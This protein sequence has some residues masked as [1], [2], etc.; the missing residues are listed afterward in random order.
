MEVR[1]SLAVHAAAAART[2]V[3]AE[4]TSKLEGLL[5]ECML[6]WYVLTCLPEP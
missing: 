4:G 6:E 5:G 2:K 1:A 3:R